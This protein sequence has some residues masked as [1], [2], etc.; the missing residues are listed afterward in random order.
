MSPFN[1]FRKESPIRGLSGLGGGARAAAAG[2][3]VEATGGTK[4][5]SGSSGCAVHT[6][7]SP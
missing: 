1:W 7:T 3:P 5:T 4:D 2:G 6:Y